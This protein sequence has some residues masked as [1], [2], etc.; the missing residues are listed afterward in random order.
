MVYYFAS[1]PVILEMSM[2]WFQNPNNEVR[3]SIVELVGVIYLNIGYAE[4][5]PYLKNLRAAQREI[6]ES[7]FERLGLGRDEHGHGGGGG[8][9]DSREGM[10][11]GMQGGMQG[12][13]DEDGNQ[14]VCEPIGG[15]GGMPGGGMP[16][17]RNQQ[18]AG[19]IEGGGDADADDEEYRCQF[20]RQITRITRNGGGGGADDNNKVLS[21]TEALDLH[22]WRECPLLTDCKYCQ[23]IIEV[24]ALRSHFLE[25]C[26]GFPM[27]EMYHPSTAGMLPPV[28]SCPLCHAEPLG[29]DLNKHLLICPE[30]KRSMGMMKQGGGGPPR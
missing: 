30:N 10:G 12:M 6:F 2:V 9:D 15:G 24:S 20:C 4:I 16:G 29:G 23:Q 7:E 18:H 21:A 13:Q 25:E 17:N 14:M 3:Q 1:A 22:Y 5:N 8:Q 11:M 26:E 19:Q 27:N 28:G